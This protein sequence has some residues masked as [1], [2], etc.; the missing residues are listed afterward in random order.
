MIVPLLGLVAFLA[1]LCSNHREPDVMK[2]FVPDQ[3][4]SFAVGGNQVAD[5]PKNDG[6]HHKLAEDEGGAE[7]AD[8]P[9]K[10]I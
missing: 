5:E 6:A 9:A 3:P 2:L 7:D 10:D 4:L 8:K 1:S